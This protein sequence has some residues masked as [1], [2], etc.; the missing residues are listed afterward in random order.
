LE[1]LLSC[2]IINDPC[3]QGGLSALV[4][5]RPAGE[6]SW[7]LL[8]HTL[9][10]LLPASLDGLKIKFSLLSFDVQGDSGMTFIL[11]NMRVNSLNGRETITYLPIIQFL[12]DPPFLQRFSV[13]G[14][15][16]GAGRSHALVKITAVA[17]SGSFL[18]QRH[19]ESHLP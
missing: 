11:K 3:P 13:F 2:L 12:M 1:F 5:V 9:P 6:G 19:L 10:G 16:S 4:S 14:K 8:Q 7:D 18:G 17:M 15:M